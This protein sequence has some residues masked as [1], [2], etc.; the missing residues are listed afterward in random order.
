MSE[1]YELRG[2]RIGAVIVVAAVAAFLVWFFVIRDGGDDNGKEAGPVAATEAEPVAATEAEIAEAAKENDQEIFWA[3]QQPSTT[4]LE[5]TETRGGNVYVRYLTGDAEIGTPKP[6][7]LTVGTYRFPNA[8]HALQ[9]IAKRPGAVTRD[10]EDGGLAVT[11][12]SSPTSVYL[13]YPGEDVQV[14]VYDPDPEK[15]LD[16]VTS[17]EIRPVP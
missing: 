11:N 17:G 7:Y 9:V 15:A 14:E 6:S 8:F 10:V 13:A 4:D 5:L 1:R 16:L 2:V 3:G 12:R